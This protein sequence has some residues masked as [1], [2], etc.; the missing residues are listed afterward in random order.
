MLSKT[1]NQISQYTAPY[2][3]ESSDGINLNETR[4]LTYHVLRKQTDGDGPIYL[5][6]TISQYIDVHFE[7]ETIDWKEP[8][9]NRY[10]G[11]RIPARACTIE[12]FGANDREKKVFENWSKGNFSLICPDLKKG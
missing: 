1:N 8:L 4:L 10:H 2:D 5:N 9:E 3:V 11:K 7:Q 6:D 12:D